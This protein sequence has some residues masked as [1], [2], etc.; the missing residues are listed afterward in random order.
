VSNHH[1]ATV[2]Q[3]IKVVRRAP[4]KTNIRLFPF[5]TARR[6]YS[7]DVPRNDKIVAS[8]RQLQRA[9]SHSKSD[10][11]HQGIEIRMKGYGAVTNGGVE[12]D[13][14]AIS[15]TNENQ[16]LLNNGNQ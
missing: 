5:L 9:G 6:R 1:L 2:H 16:P 15:S 8:Q 10:T 12:A 11:D 14:G 7:R 13:L 4:T 3:K